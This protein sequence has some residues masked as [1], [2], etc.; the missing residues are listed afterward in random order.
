MKNLYDNELVGLCLYRCVPR[1]PETCAMNPPK[2]F[3]LI[4]AVLTC[5]FTT[6]ITSISLN[7]LNSQRSDVFCGISVR[8]ASSQSG[9]R[10]HESN[11]IRIHNHKSISN[12]GW[13]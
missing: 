13:Y 6:D 3:I 12:V 8:H 10:D 1:I 11:S 5:M 9:L 2:E 7:A 4:G